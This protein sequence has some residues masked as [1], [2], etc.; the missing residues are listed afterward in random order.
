MGGGMALLANANNPGHR[1]SSLAEGAAIGAIGG[2]AGGGAMLGAAR[3]AGT[4]VAAALRGGLLAQMA[5][6]GSAGMAGGFAAGTATGLMQGKSWSDSLGMGITGG[7]MGGMLGVGLPLA[8]GGIGLA[9]RGIRGA[10]GRI[11]YWNAMRDPAERS[12]IDA[13]VEAFTASKG[14]AATPAE[15]R[16]LWFTIDRVERLNYT[17]RGSIKYEANHGI[18]LWFEGVGRNSGKFALAEAKAS[19]NLSSL[20]V[21]TVGLRQGGPAWFLARLQHAS[22][23]GVPNARMLETAFTNGRVEMF[24]GLARSQRLFQVN[25]KV[26]LHSMGDIN[27]RKTRNALLLVP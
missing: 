11:R 1:L 4:T 18:D 22:G 17:L 14:K 25:T 8:L 7:V 27:F 6:G 26:W 21:D 2:L 19:R 13:L 20:E 23:L 16:G 5:M 9:V 15:A 3:L 10:V 12:R 24:I